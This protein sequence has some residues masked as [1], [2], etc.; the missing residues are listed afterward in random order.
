MARLSSATV[1]ELTWGAGHASAFCPRHRFP[2]FIGTYVVRLLHAAGHRIPALDYILPKA[3]L[4]EGVVF[5]VCHIRQGRR[6][7]MTFDA[8]VHHAW[9]ADVG[10]SMDRPLEFEITKLVGTIRLLEFC[11]RMGSPHFV[12][13]SS[14][15]V[16][17]P[18]SPPCRS[19]N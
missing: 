7:V 1:S 15:S 4:P 3:S 6:P 12:F 18:E 14:S 17:G 10:P 9:L 13:A 16:C 2:D 8:V 5:H 11:R 19:R